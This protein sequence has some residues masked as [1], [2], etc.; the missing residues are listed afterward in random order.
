MTE[1][2]L[3]DAR[4][5]IED[6]GLPIEVVPA[7]GRQSHHEF[8]Y[9]GARVFILSKGPGVGHDLKKLRSAINRAAVA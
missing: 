2:L 8:F 1:K 6:S 5:M 4:R 3:R 7:Q 9:N